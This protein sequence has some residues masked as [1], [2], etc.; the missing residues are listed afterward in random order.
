M[1]NAIII[2][3]LAPSEGSLLGPYYDM[4]HLLNGKTFL[5]LLVEQDV[6]VKD[7]GEI[8]ISFMTF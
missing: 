2:E 3:I 1:S 4:T 8:T 5:W 7:L 6:E